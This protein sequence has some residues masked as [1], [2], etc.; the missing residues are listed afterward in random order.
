MYPFVF[1][2][3]EIFTTEGKIIL[4]FGPVTVFQNYPVTLRAMPQMR[5]FRENAELSVGA[6]GI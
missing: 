3:I 4:D 6:D 1:V 5:S 2:W